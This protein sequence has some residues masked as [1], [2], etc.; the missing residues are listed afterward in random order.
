MAE[1]KVSE[2]QRRYDMGFAAGY[3]KGLTAGRAEVGVKISKDGDEWCALVGENL[4]EGIAGFGKTPAGALF[5]LMTEHGGTLNAALG[6]EDVVVA[7]DDEP[8]L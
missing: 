8:A 1:Q 5:H 2:E 3:N 4:Q 6:G 7:E